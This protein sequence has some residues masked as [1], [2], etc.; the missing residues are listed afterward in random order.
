MLSA[1]PFGN[2]VN[3][4]RKILLLI[5]YFLLIIEKLRPDQCQKLL[6]HLKKDKCS[7]RFMCFLF[8][9][10]HELWNML[11]R[12]AAK[13]APQANSQRGAFDKLARTELNNGAMNYRY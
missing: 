13:V 7:L 3:K 8:F 5:F 1:P 4:Q 11:S 12:L 10:C 6:F 9:F 2:Q